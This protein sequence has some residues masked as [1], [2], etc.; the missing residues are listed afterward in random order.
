MPCQPL[1]QCQR[2]PPH[3]PSLQSLPLTV[4]NLH[5]PWVTFIKVLAAAL[6]A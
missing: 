1:R 2:R 5:I 4:W 6:T 3:R